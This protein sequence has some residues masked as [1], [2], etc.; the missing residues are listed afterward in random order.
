MGKRWRSVGDGYLRCLNL[1]QGMTEIV[2]TS[3]TFDDK[4]YEYIKE[5]DPQTALKKKEKMPFQRGTATDYQVAMD[6]VVSLLSTE[7]DEKFKDYLAC[8]MFLSDG[9]GGYPTSSVEHL[10]KLKKDGRKIMFFTFACET[11]EDEDLKQMAKAIGGDHYKV[12]DAEAM[13]SA[14]QTILT[15]KT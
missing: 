1:L 15:S 10:L 13:K 14:F 5:K 2:I 11:E 3:F 12:L 7:G 6:K 8:V 4:T 9:K